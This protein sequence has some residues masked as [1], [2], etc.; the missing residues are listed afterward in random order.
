[1]INVPFI[2]KNYPGYFLGLGRD[3]PANTR[4]PKHAYRII[5]HILRISILREIKTI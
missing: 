2:M 5:I 1:M 3:E 4:V